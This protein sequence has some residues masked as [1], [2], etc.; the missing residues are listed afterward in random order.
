[1]MLCKVKEKFFDFEMRCQRFRKG[2]ADVDVW[3]MNDWFQE[4]LPRMIIELRDMKQGAPEE[5]FEEVDNF[6]LLWVSEQC[7]I[8]LKQKKKKGYEKE[9]NLYN[10][11]DKI[12]DRWWLILSRIAYCLQ[13]SGDNQT[14]EIN[15]YDKLIWEEKIKPDSELRKKWYNRELEISNYRNKMKDEAFRLLKKYF[16]N[17]W[18]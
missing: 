12:F 2:Y 7:E 11:R 14:T 10:G 5:K 3:S 13:E 6:P 4:I 15:E 1:M 16:W 8:L 18:D 17:L 9:I